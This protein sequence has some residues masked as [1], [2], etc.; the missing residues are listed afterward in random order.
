MHDVI[1]IGGGPAGLTAAFWCG[2][3]GLDTL[4]IER[5]DDVGGQ[6]TQIYNCIDNYPGL[7]ANNGVEFLEKFFVHVSDGDFDQWTQA[8]I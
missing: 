6:L 8:E 5:A 4:L 1:I 7:R 3:L 2:E